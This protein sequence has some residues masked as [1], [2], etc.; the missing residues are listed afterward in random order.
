[1]LSVYYRYLKDLNRWFT[2][3]YMFIAFL[4]TKLHMPAYRCA[5]SY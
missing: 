3:R 4:S 1:M 5:E 2:L